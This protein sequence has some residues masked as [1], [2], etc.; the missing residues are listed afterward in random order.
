MLGAYY[1]HIWEEYE[2]QPIGG[3]SQVFSHFFFFCL[4]IL[5][6]WFDFFKVSQKEKVQVQ[7]YIKEVGLHCVNSVFSIY[8]F[9]C[10]AI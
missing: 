6:I 8:F 4:Q 1:A 9:F 5:C 7:W 10:N 2:G 3:G